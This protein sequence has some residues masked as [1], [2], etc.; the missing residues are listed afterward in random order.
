[1][2]SRANVLRIGFDT[3]HL[4]KAHKRVPLLHEGSAIG[5][6]VSLMHLQI[7]LPTQLLGQLKQNRHGF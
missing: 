4:G 2:G 1:M 3:E 7:A 5:I 6:D